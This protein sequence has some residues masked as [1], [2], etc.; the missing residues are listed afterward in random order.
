MYVKGLLGRKNKLIKVEIRP[1][2]LDFLLLE[3]GRSFF[4]G[5]DKKIS[6][7]ACVLNM[8]L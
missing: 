8:N 6:A 7:H 2:Q 3:P 1:D 4:G 5:V